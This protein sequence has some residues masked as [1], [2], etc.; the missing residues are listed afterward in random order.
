MKEEFPARLLRIH[1]GEADQW[2]GK[3]LHE[4]ILAKC[5][6]LGLA[7][8]VVYRGIEGYGSSTRIHRAG[9]WKLSKDAP[10]MVSV[11]DSEENL[12]RL[13]PHLDLM[14]QEGLIATSPVHVIRYT[15]NPARN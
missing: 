15:R 5:M 11:L 9:F 8:A 2:Q 10:M 14:V 1:F 13:L 3:P 4:A 6:E 12:A 7:S